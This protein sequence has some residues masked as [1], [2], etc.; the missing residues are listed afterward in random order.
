MTYDLKEFEVFATKISVMESALRHS[1]ERHYTPT[2][3]HYT[4]TGIA[5]CGGWTL[6]THGHL[7]VWWVNTAHTRALHSVV[8]EHYTPTD[9][10]YCGG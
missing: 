8:G 9:I 6:H 4:P 5:Q 1:G 2:G 3:K 7:T 10:T